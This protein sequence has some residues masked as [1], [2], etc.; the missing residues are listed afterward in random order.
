MCT[1]IGAMTNL[2]FSVK[3][4]ILMGSNNASYFI[5]MC[6]RDRYSPKLLMFLGAIGATAANIGFGLSSGMKPFA[7]F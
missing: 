1:A 7:I 5:K 2:F 4:P 3:F 6:I